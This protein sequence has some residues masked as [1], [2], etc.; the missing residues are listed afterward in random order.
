MT[1]LLLSAVGGPGVEAGVALAADHLVAVVLLSQNPEGRLNDSTTETKDQVKGGLCKAKR[2]CEHL[3]EN[4]YRFI[5][6]HRR[7]IFR[8]W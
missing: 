1:A 5:Q 4:I 3:T 2:C 6:I 7:Y 8:S